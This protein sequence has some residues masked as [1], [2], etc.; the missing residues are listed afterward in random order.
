MS[1]AKYVA[2]ANDFNRTGPLSRFSVTRASVCVARASRRD[3][4][5]PDSPQSATCMELDVIC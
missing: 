2:A 3:C 1:G 4:G 5:T